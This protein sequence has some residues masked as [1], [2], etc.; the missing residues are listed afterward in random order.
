MADNVIKLEDRPTDGQL[1]ARALAGDLAA[2]R[3]LFERYVSMAGAIAFRLT[4]QPSDVEDIVQDSFIAVFT[5]LGRLDNAEA[6]RGF[7]A[8]ITTRTAIATLRKRRLLT[9]LGLLRKEPVRLETLTSAHAPADIV[10]ELHQV[11]GVI[12]RLPAQERVTLILRRFEELTLEEI[13]E[14]TGTSLATV[15]RRLARAEQLLAA[16]LAMP[17]S[18]S[19]S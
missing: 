15:K 8:S 10:A 4:G 11:Y 1:V 7:L 14:R 16:A 19:E 3:A 2:K 6:F 17:S 18:G 13:A 12:D 5:G 9:R